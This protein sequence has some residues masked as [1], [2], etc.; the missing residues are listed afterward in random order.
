[1]RLPLTLHLLN[2]RALVLLVFTAPILPGCATPYRAIEASEVIYAGGQESNG[3]TFTYRYNV[4]SEAGSGR[5]ARRAERRGI[6]PVAVR[7]TN[8]TDTPAVLALNTVSVRTGE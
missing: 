7:V 4:M 2:V 6:Y 5:Y 1:M 8:G 3:L